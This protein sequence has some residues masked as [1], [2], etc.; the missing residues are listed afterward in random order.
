MIVGLLPNVFQS[1]SL[2]L[3]NGEVEL[4]EELLLK[5]NKKL[6]S[7]DSTKLKYEKVCVTLQCKIMLFI[8]KKKYFLHM[9]TCYTINECIKFIFFYF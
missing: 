6:V 5:L 2:Y 1:I 9:K 8:F 7:F 3:D 4:E